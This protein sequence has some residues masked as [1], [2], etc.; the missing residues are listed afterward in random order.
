MIWFRR[1]RNNKPPSTITNHLGMKFV[2][3]PPGTFTM[4]SPKEE[5]DRGNNESPHKVTLTKGFYLSVH[6]VTQWPWEA[7]MGS[8]P[9]RFKGEKTLPVEGVSWED[10]LEMIQKLRAKEK[11]EYRLPS[12]AEWEYACRAGT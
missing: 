8:N 9:S 1:N 6:L 2:W 11:H 10:C 4:G 5:V 3:I 12:E 7:V